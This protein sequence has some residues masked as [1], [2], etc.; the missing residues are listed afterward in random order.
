MVTGGGW[1]QTAKGWM[2][3][4]PRV[5]LLFLSGSRT[6][7]PSATALVSGLHNIHVYSESRK[8]PRKKRIVWAKAKCIIIQERRVRNVVHGEHYVN[9]HR[10]CC[11]YHSDV[12]L[13]ALQDAAEKKAHDIYDDGV[14]VNGDAEDR[15]QTINS[16]MQFILFTSH[17][18][19]FWF[20]LLN[21]FPAL[22]F[23]AASLSPCVN[24]ARIN[25]NVAD[26]SF[27]CFCG[28]SRTRR[29][30]E[31]SERFGIQ[32]TSLRYQH[33]QQ[34]DD[35]SLK[36]ILNRVLWLLVLLLWFMK[37]CLQQGR[38]LKGA[39]NRD[40]SSGIKKSTKF[41]WDLITNHQ[42]SLP[43]PINLRLR[44]YSNFRWWK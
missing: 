44:R 13:K 3:F 15:L 29:S 12:S 40:N 11:S 42:E 2:R 37:R 19:S 30:W 1:E 41:V 38:A 20:F 7:F 10:R 22:L 18:V 35:L 14:V 25:F 4:L 39:G 36:C 26:K 9:S 43:L 32:K 33:T 28:K 34:C 27:L 21:S 23:A 5:S 31:T 17:N 16:S 8:F 6:T 24:L